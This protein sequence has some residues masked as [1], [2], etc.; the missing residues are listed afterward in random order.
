MNGNI[1]EAVKSGVLKQA[2]TLR[3]SKEIEDEFKQGLVFGDKDEILSGGF[4][5]TLAKVSEVRV[6]KLTQRADFS[7]YILL[8]TKFSFPAT[9]RIYGYIMS[10]VRKAR[11]G[12]KMAGEL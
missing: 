1:E 4:N 5:T 12:L 6:Q 9:V 11:K 2:T 8:P 3:V 7:D 10:F